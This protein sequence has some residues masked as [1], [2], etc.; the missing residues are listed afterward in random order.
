MGTPAPD[1]VKRPVYRFDQDHKVLLSG[2]CKE[3]HLPKAKTPHERES[4]QRQIAATDKA[5]DALVYELYGLTEEEIRIVE[6]R[7]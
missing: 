2:D 1:A 6:G 7:E 5:I 3:E 4:L